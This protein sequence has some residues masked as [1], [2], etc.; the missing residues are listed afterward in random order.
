MDNAT[1]VIASLR[2]LGP[3]W[4]LKDGSKEIRTTD[5]L[6]RKHVIEGPLAALYSPTIEDNGYCGKI[7]LLLDNKTTVINIS[8]TPSSNMDDILSLNRR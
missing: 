5:V 1:N 6:F 7:Q 3:I 2:S 4:V 8:T